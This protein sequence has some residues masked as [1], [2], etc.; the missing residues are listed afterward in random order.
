[1]VKPSKEESPNLIWGLFSSVKLAIVL[2]IILAIASILGTVIPQQNGAE[3]FA[4]QLSPAMLRL[5]QTLNFFDMYHS[6]WFR[7]LIGLL[8]LNLIVCSINRFPKTLKKFSALPKP[9]RS[10]PFENLPSTQTFRIKGSLKGT[11][12]TVA[13]FLKS[14][15]KKTQDK[16][17]H[18]THYF[19]GEKGRFSHFGV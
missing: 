12:E 15:Y 4:K 1:M 6:L 2:L 10:K 11:S 18:K 3:E 19:Y 8:S 13:R 7:L 5:F 17:S 9:N 14:K 16:E